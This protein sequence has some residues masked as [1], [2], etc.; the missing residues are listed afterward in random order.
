MG[1]RPWVGPGVGGFVSASFGRILNAFSSQHVL[2]VGDAMLDEYLTGDCSRLSPEAPVPILT[3]TGSRSVLGGAANTASN[4]VSL[5]G[6]AMLIGVVGKDE[7]GAKLTAEAARVG[8]EF[9]TVATSRPTVRKVRVLGQQQQLLRMDYESKPFDQETDAAVLAA[10][11]QA[12][13]RV[14]A[15]ILSDYAK[16]C[17]SASL[18]QAII[19]AAKARGVLVVVDPRPRNGDGYVGCDYITP[20]WREARQLAR[21]PEA[22][23]S[24]LSVDEI[25]RSVATRFRAHALLT[26]GARGM[27]LFAPDGQPVVEVA[28]R[29][30]EVFDVSGA[31]DTVVAALTL[32]LASGA[33]QAEAVHI[34]NAA[35]GI[36]VGKLGTSTVTVAELTGSSTEDRAPITRAELGEV[37][38]RLRA[39]GRRIVTLNGSFDVLHAGHL[40]IIQEARRQGDVLIVG[41]NSDQSVRAL[42]GPA[43]PY[44][45]EQDRARL[46]LA[47]RDVDYVHIFDES[48]P[49]AFLDVVRPDVHVNGSE[50]GADCIEAPTVRAHGGRVH[51][52]DRVAGL[53]TTA[54]VQR[55]QGDDTPRLR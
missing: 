10:V 34:A 36:V 20:N 38:T 1:A 3:V 45:G 51:L 28:A 55:I 17:L 52:V 42:K 41:L 31:G 33:S 19:G 47:L 15:V 6:R 44:I 54:L 2:V 22:A 27:K 39:D 16:G 14:A 35:A 32:A 48:T 9:T 8:I 23:M 29:S 37:A 30:R 40:H 24:E 43:R 26:L 11:T 53:S 50:Y 5:G 12:L 25:G 13:P 49:V 46:L 7:T 18:C 21:L 4:I